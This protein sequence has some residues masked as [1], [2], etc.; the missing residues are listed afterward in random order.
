MRHRLAPVAA[1]RSSID[2]TP[3]VPR[4]LSLAR[5]IRYG[6]PPPRTKESVLAV[7]GFTLVTAAVVSPICGVITG[8]LTLAC[9]RWRSARPLLTIG[10]P[11][12]LVV[13]GLYDV[14]FQF[15]HRVPT[16]FNWPQLLDRVH[17]LG[18]MAVVLLLVDV[19]V[20]RLWLRRWWPT[21]DSP[22]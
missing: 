19:V 9:V 4:S 10:S 22:A 18:W 15:R 3:S 5:S 7:V 14:V 21:D 20:D 6:G 12:C 11:L 17:T 16:D 1:G 13:V 2:R 8:L